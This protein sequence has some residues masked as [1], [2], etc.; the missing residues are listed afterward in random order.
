MRMQPDDASPRRHR[1]SGG[2]YDF[3]GWSFHPN[4]GATMRTLLYRLQ[5]WF[6]VRVRPR[7]S[8]QRQAPASNTETGTQDSARSVIAD[9][10][11]LPVSSL[12]RVLAI[13]AMIVEL[14]KRA[15]DRQL[16]EEVLELERLGS[17]HLPRLVQSYVDI[18]PE[19][20]SEIFRET[21]RSASFLLN[22]RLDKILARLHEMSRQLAR[23]NLDA[24]SENIRF[25]DMRYGTSPF[26]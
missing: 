3:H 19:H 18:P 16:I 2:L 22:E 26:D 13:R 10:Q 4:E 17:T 25:V 8:E 24:F 7:S 15:R 1:V 5:G 11:R 23:G 12:D 20:R 21:G 6:G 9:E 14:E